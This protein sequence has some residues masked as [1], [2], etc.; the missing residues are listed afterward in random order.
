MW[1]QN[2]KAKMKLSKN[3]KIT[4][5]IQTKYPC[6]NRNDFDMDFRGY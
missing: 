5:S 4:Y 2:I 6:E 1:F 3:D